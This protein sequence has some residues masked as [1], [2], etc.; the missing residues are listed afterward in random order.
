MFLAGAVA[1]VG[2]VTSSVAATGTVAI[3]DNRFDPQEIR[4]DPGDRVVWTNQGARVHT[5][6][7]DKKDDFDSGNLQPGDPF[8]HQFPKEGYY[9]YFCRQHGGRNQV[10]MW[11]VVIVGDLPPPEEVEHEKDDR[12]TLV[13]PKDFKTIQKAVNAAKPGSTIVIQPGVY[14]EQVFVKTPNLI[15]RGV[16]RFRTILNGG[17]ELDNG[18]VVD[19]ANNVAIKN[20][21][22]RNYLGNGIY[23]FNMK[24]Y[25][26]DK[27]DA[28]KNRV[29]GIYAFDSYEGVI[30]NSFGW[31]SGD[32]AFYVGQ[33]LGCAAVLENIISQYNYLGYSGTNATGVVIRDSV[34]KN[35]GA[36]I[37]PNTLPTEELP[38]NRGTFMYNNL[39]VNNNYS[40]VPPAGFSETV[41]IPF[42]TGIWFAGIMNSEAIGNT[43]RNH[44]R[45]G[46]LITQ[47]IQ[48]DSIPMNNRVLDNF[49]RDSGMYDL[50]WDGTGQDNC[51]SGN[52]ITGETGPPSM[53]ETYSCDARPFTGVPY[54]PVQADVAA[55]L[56]GSQTREWEEGPEP[57]R[58]NCQ[59]GA[60]GC[61]R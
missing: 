25:T 47:S 57:K 13:V 46:I 30:K 1:S 38:P 44:D 45:Y 3:R 15:I 10:G 34:F 33:C 50:A 54:P 24:G 9:F 29:Y 4:I 53:Q 5:V 26:A 55:S 19:G 2:L 23:F 36:G 7:S 27:I 48:Q 60:P 8:E 32:S 28:I 20:M 49:V 12:P 52:D 16:D 11:G 41:G 37:V 14:R 42:G 21:T 22:V 56:G 51:F 43:V 6:T 40:T 59:K 58:P 35:N 61:K 39:V 17:D 18:F 31:G